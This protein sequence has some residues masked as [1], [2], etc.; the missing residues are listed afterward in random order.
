M[1]SMNFPLRAPHFTPISASWGYPPA[2]SVHRPVLGE[3]ANAA[4][5]IG[6]PGKEEAVPW[7]NLWIDLGGEG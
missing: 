1:N 4:G 7:E 2:S 3:Q 5:H 6:E